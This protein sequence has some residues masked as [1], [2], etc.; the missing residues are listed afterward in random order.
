M[1]ERTAFSDNGKRSDS[2]G[3]LLLPLFELVFNTS[4]ALTDRDTVSKSV[5]E[6][7]H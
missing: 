3:L 6:S 1:P 7:G 4:R 5:S 2:S